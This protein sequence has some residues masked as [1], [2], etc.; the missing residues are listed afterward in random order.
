MLPKWGVVWQTKDFVRDEVFR[1]RCAYRKISL[2]VCNDTRSGEVVGQICATHIPLVLMTD[3]LPLRFS[4]GDFCLL[5][6]S[7][8]GVGASS[9]TH[10]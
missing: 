3:I 2:Y 4:H 8:E 1:T 5:I 7:V 10:V 9:C 6:A